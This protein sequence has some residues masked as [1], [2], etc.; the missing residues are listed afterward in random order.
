LLRQ[1]EKIPEG[2]YQIRAL[3]K[4]RL[5]ISRPDRRVHSKNAIGEFLNPHILVHLE[6]TAYAAFALKRAIIAPNS[7]IGKQ[8]FYLKQQNIYVSR[9]NLRK[10]LEMADRD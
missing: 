4:I 8:S 6:K 7:G 5:Y 3:H 9:I 2:P 1:R 10:G